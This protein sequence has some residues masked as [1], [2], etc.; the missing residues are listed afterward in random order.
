V[1]VIPITFLKDGQKVGCL[2]MLTPVATPQ[3]IVIRE[4]RVETCFQQTT[5]RKAVI[6][7]LM[8]RHG[9]SLSH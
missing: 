1:P 2:S 8:D 3:T 6:L 7:R 9:L 4:L 5:K